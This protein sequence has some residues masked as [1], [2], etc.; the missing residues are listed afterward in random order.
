MESFITNPKIICPMH[1]EKTIELLVDFLS[2]TAE[3]TVQQNDVI[4]AV[5]AKRTGEKL[6]AIQQ[7]YSL[8]IK[9]KCR[10]DQNPK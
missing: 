5:R 2:E 8:K 6:S 7:S 9:I 10:A 3:A 1:R 4:T